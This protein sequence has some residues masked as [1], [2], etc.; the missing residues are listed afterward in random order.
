MFGFQLY[1]RVQK[2]L[3]VYILTKEYG[4]ERRLVD[5]TASF[6]SDFADY[7]HAS[8]IFEIL[9]VE[10]MLKPLYF[11][12]VNNLRIKIGMDHKPQVAKRLALIL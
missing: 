2:R 1:F 6:C 11:H 12:H 4:K 5:E 7:F 9:E 8:N 10:F 3:L